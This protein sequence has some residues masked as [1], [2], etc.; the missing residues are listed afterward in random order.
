MYVLTLGDLEQITQ[1]ELYRSESTSYRHTRQQGGDFLGTQ[2]RLFPL[3]QWL[4]EGRP[5]GGMW[6]RSATSGQ[7]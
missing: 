1:L 6:A 7:A 4:K 5:L 3:K 2:K